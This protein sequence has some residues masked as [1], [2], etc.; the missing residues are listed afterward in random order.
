MQVLTG[1]APCMDLN[2][3][4]SAYAVLFFKNAACGNGRGGFKAAL[5]ATCMRDSDLWDALKDWSLLL[6]CLAQNVPE[7]PHW[8][9]CTKYLGKTFYGFFNDVG[10]A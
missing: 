3:P 9:V 7:T 4:L 10:Y 1:V 6:Q 8:A 2:V 5:K